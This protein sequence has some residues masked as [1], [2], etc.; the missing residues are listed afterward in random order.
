VARNRR[1]ETVPCSQEGDTMKLSSESRVAIAIGVV[2]LL[3]AAG[4]F[5]LSPKREGAPQ[6]A[7][8][9]DPVPAAIHLV[10]PAQR[11]YVVP[12]PT[13]DQQKIEALH[14]K[15]DEYLQKNK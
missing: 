13:A 11:Y 3:A 10:V 1:R 4:W 2:L 15:Y 5:I 6:K 8:L 7:A 9:G 12:E 14:R